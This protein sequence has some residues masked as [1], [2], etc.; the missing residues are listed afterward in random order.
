[1][2]IYIYIK[3]I[4][5]C[6][7]VSVCVYTQMSIHTQHNQATRFLLLRYLVQGIVFSTPSR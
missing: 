1:M 4:Y 7:C 2:Y 6:V 3:Y 5:I